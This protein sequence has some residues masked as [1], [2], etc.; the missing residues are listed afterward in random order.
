MN[1]DSV[2]IH[3]FILYFCIYYPG[4]IAKAQ[5]PDSCHLVQTLEPPRELSIAHFGQQGLSSLTNRG[6]L[7]L[8]GLTILD[9]AHHYKLTHNK[10]QH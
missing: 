8:N 1:A 3:V 6:K 9:I 4:F 2:Y 7:C 10:V 5:E